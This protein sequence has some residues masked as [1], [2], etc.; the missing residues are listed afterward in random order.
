MHATQ[1]IAGRICRLPARAAVGAAWLSRVRSAVAARVL[2]A[3]AL[4]TVGLATSPARAEPLPAGLR[5]VLV[6]DPGCSYC[7]KWLNEVGPYY[8]T[9]IQGQRAPLVRRQTGDESLKGF[10]RLNYTPTFLLVRDGREIDR[11]VG[12][13]GAAEFWRQLRAML[14]KLDGGGPG[15]APGGPE[16]DA[17]AP[18][19]QRPSDE[20]DTLLIRPEP[21]AGG[22]VRVG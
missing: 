8:A 3:A 4:V 19:P 7:R 21:G 16:D 12:Y 2:L 14:A 18:Q 22:R 10:G 15:E 13:G 20:R 17:P 5:L 11:L 9:S 1:V 6:E